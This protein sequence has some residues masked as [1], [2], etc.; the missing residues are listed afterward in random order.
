AALAVGCGE[1]K[2]TEAKVTTLKPGILMMSSDTPYTPFEFMEGGKAVGFD[3]DVATEM[4]KR[5]NVKLDVVPTAWDVIIPGLKYDKYDIIMSAM[6]ITR[7]RSKEISFSDPYIDS[8]QSIAVKIGTPIKNEA[9]LKGKVIGV[10][11][12][13]MGQMTAEKMTGLK[14]IRKFNTI[15]LAF[16][17]LEM[18]GIDAIINDYPVNAYMSK[19]MGKTEVVH[20]IITREKYGIGV[21]KENNQL[22]LAINEELKKLKKDG[23]YDNIYKKWFGTSKTT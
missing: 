16:E 6:P 9:D 11:I 14:E 17:D 10:Q 2:T 22:R 18:G 7:E 19:K 23:T 20:K 3:V 12:D 1:K 15:L 21:K 8:D 13:T 5:L 4:A